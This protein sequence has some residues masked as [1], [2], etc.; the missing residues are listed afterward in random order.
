MSKAASTQQ[1]AGKNFAGHIH[2]VRHGEPDLSRAIW[3]TRRGFNT[4]WIEYGRVGLAPSALPPLALTQ[5]AAKAAVL[6]ASPVQRARATAERLAEKSGKAHDIIVDEI[7]EEMPLPAP[8]LLPFLRLPPPLW[9]TVARFAWWLGY[10]DGGESRYEAETR[11]RRAADR[12]IGLAADHGGDVV[13]CGHGWFI[14]MAGKELKR[15]GWK[16]VKG[17]GATFWDHKSFASPV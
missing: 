12:L 7:Y 6:V 13:L 2:M 1:Q 15:R 5:I 16:K 17:G 14:H 9:G 11:A 4:W 8:L 10:A 3:L